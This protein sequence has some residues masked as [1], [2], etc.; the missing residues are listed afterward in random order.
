MFKKPETYFYLIFL[1]Y[2][3]VVFG[4]KPESASLNLGIF[5]LNNIEVSD[6]EFF[7]RVASILFASL[8]V[9]VNFKMP[10]ELFGRHVSKCSDLIEFTN[11]QLQKRTNNSNDRVSSINLNGFFKPTI[12]TGAWTSARSQGQIIIEPTFWKAF[13]CRV[14][15]LSRA[16]LQSYT[17]FTIPLIG[18]V[19]LILS[20]I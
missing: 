9:I 14:R 5:T 6:F 2:I 12:D 16:I 15:A 8:S 7:L 17:G 4:A 20:S 13:A 1:G 3:L 10:I 19:W 11:S 18:A